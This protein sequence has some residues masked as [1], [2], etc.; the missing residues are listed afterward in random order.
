M[1]FG[2]AGTLTLQQAWDVAAWIDSQPRP[3]DPRFTGERREDPH[4]VSQATR[5][6]YYG[7]A[8]DGL[9]LGV[10]GTLEAWLEGMPPRARTSGFGGCRRPEPRRICRGSAVSHVKNFAS[11][12]G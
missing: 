8:V 4:P 10:P 7:A 11:R 6:R 5:L 9:T 1:P 3:Q 2:A 12:A